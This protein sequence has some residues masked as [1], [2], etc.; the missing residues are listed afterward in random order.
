M[1]RRKRLSP[2]ARFNVTC[3]YATAPHRDFARA[4]KQLAT[5]IDDAP[6]DP[7]QKDRRLLAGF[8]WHDESLEHLRVAHH[9]DLE[10]LTAPYYALDSIAALFPSE[11]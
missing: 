5:A 4:L 11:P 8:V 2:R 9:A 6:V 7:P 10:L 3:Y 1:L